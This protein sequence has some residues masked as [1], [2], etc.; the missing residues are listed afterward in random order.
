MTTYAQAETALRAHLRDNWAALAGT[1][2]HVTQTGF[3]NKSFNPPSSE[4]ILFLID[5]P[6]D[7]EQVALGVPFYRRDI[8]LSFVIKTPLNL[9]SERHAA[10]VDAALALFE[11][12]PLDG[13]NLQIVNFDR[14]GDDERGFFRSNGVFIFQVDHLYT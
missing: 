11:N 6:A 3:D 4:H 12:D 14:V 1:W 10:L 5:P 8:E 9:D 13:I 2:S 7:S